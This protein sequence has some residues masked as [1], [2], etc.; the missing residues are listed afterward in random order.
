MSEYIAVDLTANNAHMYDEPIDLGWGVCRHGHGLLAFGDGYMNEA[1]ARARADA[2]NRGEV[3]TSVV[4]CDCSNFVLGA[5]WPMATNGDDSLPWVERCDDCQTFP[6]DEAAAEAIAA[7]IG[8]RVMWA[9]VSGGLSPFVL[10]TDFP[11]PAGHP[12]RKDQP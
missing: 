7:K 4:N 1:I 6:D 8:G 9:K 5:I 10:P 11:L 2:L 12:L 3:G